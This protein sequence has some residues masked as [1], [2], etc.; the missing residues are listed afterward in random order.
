ML[1][2][3][4]PTSPSTK[5]EKTYSYRD[6]QIF[7]ILERM[8]HNY[9]QRYEICPGVYHCVPDLL[10]HI[11]ATRMSRYF[12]KCNEK[13]RFLNTTIEVA[14]TWNRKTVLDPRE[15]GAMMKGE[16]AYQHLLNAS[17]RKLV[18]DLDLDSYF[19]ERNTN[20]SWYGT[21]LTKHYYRQNG[22]HV[23]KTVPFSNAL[24]HPIDGE[25]H[26]VGER[27]C[28]S[29]HDLEN[30]QMYDKDSVAAFAMDVRRCA[31]KDVDAS[32]STIYL[33]EIHG[34]F[35]AELFNKDGKASFDHEEPNKRGMFVVAELDENLRTVLYIGETDYDV[36]TIE[37]LESVLGRTMGVGPA[38]SMISA[39][40]T[41]N[42]L[43]NLILDQIRTSSVT[44]FQ[45][46][47]KRLKKVK[48]RNLE[49]G[50]MPIIIHDDEKPITKMNSDPSGFGPSTSYMQQVILLNRQSASI[51]EGALGNSVKSNTSFAAFQANAKE[52]DGNYVRFKKLSFFSFRKMAKKPGNLIHMICSGADTQE[53]VEDLLSPYQ[54]YA[55]KRL[56]AGKKAEIEHLKQQEE[57]LFVVDT[58]EQ[59]TEFYLEEDKGVRFT[60]KV[61]E[62][63]TKKEIREKIT[64]TIGSEDDIIRKKLELLERNYQLVRDNPQ[65]HTTTSLEEIRREMNDLSNLTLNHDINITPTQSGQIGITPTGPQVAQSAGLLDSNALS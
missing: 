53:E 40:I 28:I 6:S 50:A 63:M 58:I 22:E 60:L 31:G 41:T 34:F 48:L 56:I 21:N 37:K 45:S 4:T 64:L 62:D 17:L 33:Y 25:H 39:Q 19:I 54:L 30:M 2:N 47:D 11:N 27:W 57:G 29:L 7:S 55:W 13:Y 32:V 23:Y 44:I 59:L 49:Y 20:F 65:D 61:D 52:A 43:H 14:N 26:P 35:P 24:F 42:E 36:Y 51:T 16:E 1:L 12:N 9:E 8:L 15:I 5:I 38:E 18:C 10:K 46:A 3:T